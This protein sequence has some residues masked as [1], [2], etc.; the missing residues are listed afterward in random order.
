MLRRSTDELVIRPRLSSAWRIVLAVVAVVVV[1]VASFAGYWGGRDAVYGQ[2]ESRAREISTLEGELRESR[3]LRKSLEARLQATRDQLDVTREQLEETK[4]SLTKV[5]RQLQIDKSAYKELR[6]ELE[7]SNTEITDLAS[8]LKFYRSII[9]PADGRSGVRIQDFQVE[10]VDAENEYRYRL[11]LIQA[12]EH[13]DSVKGMVRFEISGTQDDSTR[14]IHV[15]VDS[16]EH[17]VA[18]FKYFQNFAGTLK[19]PTGFMPAEITVIFEAEDDA[20]VKRNYPWP[21]RRPRNV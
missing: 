5:T 2:L 19:L 8:E 18:E 16:G 6:K 17:I 1:T 15:P 3:N 13:E 4:S 10:S 11:I 21:V 14:T 12:L 7:A 9:S 20:V